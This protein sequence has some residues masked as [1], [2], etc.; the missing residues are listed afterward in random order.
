[1][2]APAVADA[3]VI[4]GGGKVTRG[5]AVDAAYVY[6][7][8]GEAL[9]RAPKDGSGPPVLVAGTPPGDAW[10]PSVATLVVDD[11]N[12]YWS[13]TSASGRVAAA[14]K[15]G[16]PAR[17][18]ASDQWDTE[19]AVSDGGLWGWDHRGR[20]WRATAGRRAAL[21]MQDA[22]EGGSYAFR[23]SHNVATFGGRAFVMGDRSLLA[24]SP[25]GRVEAV[26][27][28]ESFPPLP[29]PTYQEAG[30][31]AVD[32]GGA[33]LALDDQ[34]IA[35]HVI[36]DVAYHARLVRLPRGGRAEERA[37]LDGYWSAIAA[38][39]EAVYLSIG[40]GR[41][42]GGDE[43]RFVGD[44]RLLR[45]DRGGGAPVVLLKRASNIGPLAVDGQFVYFVAG[46]NGIERVAKR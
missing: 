15:R 31:V 10:R 29:P 36:Q 39:N 43:Q 3:K 30:F 7:G 41:W 13:T 25:S 9:M 45:V 5:L 44:H 34:R 23:N 38:D 46:G 6:F 2:P 37:R 4:V 11:A 42:A 21:V 12:V 35:H 40:V 33:W 26:P 1:M 24:V 18:V 14:N 22:Q 20:L 16:G 17:L 27:F 28:A 8:W 32:G 19:L